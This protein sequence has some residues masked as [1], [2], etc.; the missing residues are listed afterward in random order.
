MTNISG[1]L[2]F[3][4][5]NTLEI[6]LSLFVASVPLESFF[7]GSITGNIAIALIPSWLISSISFKTESSPNLKIPGIDSIGSLSLKP[8]FTNTGWI[9]SFL[10]TAH[11]LVKSIMDSD[12]LNLR[13]LV[14]GYFLEIIN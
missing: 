13:N 3:I 4:E 14:D 12:C 5:P 2:D 1:N 6:K 10:V 9:R 11:S 8:S 7:E